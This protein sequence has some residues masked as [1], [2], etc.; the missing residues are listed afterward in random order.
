MG[1]WRPAHIE[2]WDDMRITSLH[3]EQNSI[4]AGRALLTA[5]IDVEATHAGKVTLDFRLSGIAANLG[6]G[7]AVHG[8]ET[9]EAGVNHLRY[10][11]RIDHPKLWFPAGYGAQ[12]RYRAVLEVRNEGGTKLLDVASG[13]R[14]SACIRAI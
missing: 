12:N 7:L 13:V 1:I 6:D 2:A 14:F 9:L 10:S 3:I 8:T 11:L 5:E 4:T